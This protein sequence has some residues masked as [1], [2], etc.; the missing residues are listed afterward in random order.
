M[1]QAKQITFLS[2]VSSLPLAA[3]ALTNSS[4]PSVDILLTLQAL[5]RTFSASKV[6]PLE[7]SQR[8]DSGRINQSDINGSADKPVMWC[9][10]SVKEVL[11]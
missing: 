11:N 4:R 7:R 9:T 5:R 3:A 1:G 8:G 6:F 10:D 2:T